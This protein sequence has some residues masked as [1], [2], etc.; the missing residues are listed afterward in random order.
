MVILNYENLWKFYYIT[1]CISY[2]VSNN[3]LGKSF[4]EEC[5]KKCTEARGYILNLIE[6]LKTGSITVEELHNLT[7]HTTQVLKLC[8]VVITEASVSLDLAQLIAQRNSEL[9]KFKLHHSAVKFLL[10]Y[11][12]DISEGM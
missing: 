4:S 3:K 12:Q 7:S 9:D 8:S 10:E 6:R 11:C 5:T 2:T 1:V